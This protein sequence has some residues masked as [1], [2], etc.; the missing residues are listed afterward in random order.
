MSRKK[1]ESQKKTSPKMREGIL[2]A[3]LSLA[4]KEP[5][6][7]VSLYAIALEAG[8]ELDDVTRLF[9][10]KIDIVRAITDD[11]DAK[12]ERA[13][14]ETD[15]SIP[16]RDRLF[17]V[18]M[19]RL[20]C[21]SP[22]RAAH[23]SFLKSFG[24]NKSESCVSASLVANSMSRMAKLA[25]VDTNGALGALRMLALGAAFGWVIFAWAKDAS[26]DLTKTMA[27]LDRTLDR[28]EKLG[29]LF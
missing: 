26:P 22:H 11:L 3:A 20:E 28:L 6:Q 8:Y 5:W 29:G 16:V 21:A 2:A 13:F 27:E 15:D 19:E 23:L 4:A 25:G 9:P 18:L 1:A 10:E 12:I 17:D 24:W 7:F 14:D